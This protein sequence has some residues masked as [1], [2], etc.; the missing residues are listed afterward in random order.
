[1]KYCKICRSAGNLEIPVNE[2]HLLF[3]HGIQNEDLE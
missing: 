2:F 1:M 3:W